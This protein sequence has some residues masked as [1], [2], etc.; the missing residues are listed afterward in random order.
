[1]DMLEACVQ[2]IGLVLLRLELPGPDGV[3]LL[4]HLTAIGFPGAVAIVGVVDER[5]A[6]AVRQFA[7]ASSLDLVGTFDL[8]LDAERLALALE[9]PRPKAC[10]RPEANEAWIARFDDS[11]AKGGIVNYYQPLVD[12]G[13]CRTVAMEALAR[14]HGP[15]GALHVAEEFIGRLEATGRIDV[16]ALRLIPAALQAAAAW[17]RACAGLRIALNVSPRTLCWTGFPDFLAEE[18]G[19]AGLEPRL[20]TVEVTENLPFDSP[21]NHLDCILRLHLKGFHLSL[22]DFGIGHASVARLRDL[23][24]DELK[25]DRS[26]VKNC[27]RDPRL[28][29]VVEASLA[30]ARGFGVRTVAEG[31]DDVADFRFLQAAGCDMVQGQL[32][33]GALSEAEA[34]RWIRTKTALPGPAFSAAVASSECGCTRP[35]APWPHPRARR[36]PSR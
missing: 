8:P 24:I 14:W 10:V 28:G 21:L 26:F 13:T 23:P 25:L 6:A 5:A 27:S 4:R 2:D 34:G 3:E 18:A 19:Q 30:M 33:S 29:A 36:S 22:D 17:A 15:D 16:L 1:M 31:V 7:L 32:V 12:A 20:V 11:L 9:R 35:P